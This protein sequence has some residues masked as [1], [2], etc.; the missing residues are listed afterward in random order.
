M[1]AASVGERSA[2]L[3]GDVSVDKKSTGKSVL[4]RGER[5]LGGELEAAAFS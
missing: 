5:G 3:K 4:E 2:E 1:G